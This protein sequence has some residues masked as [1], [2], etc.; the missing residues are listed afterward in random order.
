MVLFCSHHQSYLQQDLKTYYQEFCQ[1]CGFPAS[2]EHLSWAGPAS[3]AEA[4]KLALSASLADR[5]GRFTCDFLGFFHQT[6][7]SKTLIQKWA[8][9]RSRKH[10]E[11]T[12]WWGWHWLPAWRGPVS[13][14]QHLRARTLWGPCPAVFTYGCGLTI[15]PGWVAFKPNTLALRDLWTI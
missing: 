4:R 2:L 3:I 15:I 6:C 14:P 8:M 5:S 10:L 13:S 11:P 1:G 7:Q 12:F 9:W